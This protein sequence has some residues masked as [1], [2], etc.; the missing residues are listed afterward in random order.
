[1]DA[2]TPIPTAIPSTRKTGVHATND[3]PMTIS[4]RSAAT[5]TRQAAIGNVAPTR[6]DPPSDEWLAR[7]HGQRRAART[8]GRCRSSRSRG[9]PCRAGTAPP[10]CPPRRRAP[11]RPGRRPT[12]VAAAGENRSG[13]RPRRGGCAPRAAP[14]APA[15]RPRP[16]CP[17]Y[18]T[19]GVRRPSRLP[20]AGPTTRPSPMASGDDPHAHPAPLRLAG[21]AGHERLGRHPCRHRA[22]TAESLAQSE[23]PQ[24]IG[25]RE[26][27]RRRR[28]RRPSPGTP[29]IGPPR[30]VDD[31]SQR[32]RRDQ[33]RHREGRERVGQ[34]G[35]RG[36]EQ[37]RE[38]RYGRHHHP[39][40]RHVGEDG[41]A[42][43]HEHR[44]AAARIHQGRLEAATGPLPDR[45][46]TR[47]GVVRS[48]SWNRS[49]VC[50]WQVKKRTWCSRGEIQQHG[51]GCPGADGVEVDQHVVHD[52]RHR[53]GPAGELRRQPQPQAQVQLLHG[54]ATEPVGRLGPSSLVAARENL[55]RRPRSPDRTA[56]PVI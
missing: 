20:R 37:R 44:R 17:R 54:A 33:E 9:S 25:E 50:G 22:N 2:D 39:D 51:G 26:A 12:Y 48:T 47:T 1:M 14:P 41:Q 29:P 6:L 3:V 27:E 34:S 36:S 35:L 55:R 4:V 31:V 56:P 49:T 23:D 5:S 11:A 42:A 53:R 21:D 38:L 32:E 46:S 24:S 28:P 15:P 16:R 30:A 52:D 10:S 45:G 43:H 8:T 18:A 13:D 40:A 19:K 7:G